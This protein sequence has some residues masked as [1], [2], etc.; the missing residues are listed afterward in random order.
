M[1]IIATQI[2]AGMIVVFNK[3]LCRVTEVK[4]VTPGKGCG[5]VQVKMRNLATGSKAEN[6]FRSDEKLEKAEL[7]ARPMEFLYETDGQY[8]FMDM[9]NYEQTQL[10]DELLGDYKLYLISNLQVKV[11]FYAGSPVGIEL[12]KTVDLEVT[13]TGPALKNA[14]VTTSYK[15]A[16]LETGLSLGVPPFI[17][18]GEKVRVDTAEGKYLERA[19]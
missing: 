16:T 19:K 9:E 1:I 8:H 15:P 10:S 13:E 2:R 7:D 4:H 6:R 17:S 18:Q 12:P 3:S 11:E 14:T 5:M